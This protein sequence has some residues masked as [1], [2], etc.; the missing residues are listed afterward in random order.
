MEGGACKFSPGV[1]DVVIVPCRLAVDLGFDVLLRQPAAA[2]VASPGPYSIGAV[3]VLNVH[4]AGPD[5]VNSHHSALP[6]M[7]DQRSAICELLGP[8]AQHG[9]GLVP[10]LVAWLW[11]WRR[12]L[13][14]VRLAVHGCGKQGL[15]ARSPSTGELG[16]A[17]PRRDWRAVRAKSSRWSATSCTIAGLSEA[18]AGSGKWGGEVGADEEEVCQTV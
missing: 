2:H 18:A 3:L 9:G 1:W 8:S 11:R 16:Q 14:L 5:H 17:D 6:V 10:E 12:R 13:R 4:V 7:I 15:G